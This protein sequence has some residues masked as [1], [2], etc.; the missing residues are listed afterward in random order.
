VVNLS[1]SG[2]LHVTTDAA[3]DHSPE[4]VL[5]LVVRVER[6]APPSRTDAL[7]SAARAVL[8]MLTAE[9]P[10][11][12]DAVQAWDGGRI[13]KVVRRAR[14]AEWRRVQ[15]LPGITVAQGGAE[16]R[17]YPPILLDAWPSEL[18][19]L[20]VE[21]T[22]LDDPEPP[23]APD[24][25]LPLILI[26]PHVQMSAGKAMAQAGHA[27]QLGWRAVTGVQRVRWQER[28]YRT[29]VRTAGPRRW[30]AA[31]RAGAPVVRDA[32]FTEVAPGAETAAF[33]GSG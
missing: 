5:P 33:V 26:S 2:Q 31:L 8:L 7:E 13:R 15:S 29:A 1:V 11:W 22:T 20:Q 14:G 25:D 23:P 32:G 24:P 30:R 12:H 6:D 9:Q 18:S 28:D 3:T 4:L 19:R 17:V 27:A 16:V 21:G 10:D